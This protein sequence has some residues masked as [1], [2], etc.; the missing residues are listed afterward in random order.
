MIV[1]KDVFM[2]QRLFLSFCLLGMGLLLVGCGLLP[3]GEEEAAAT[4]VPAPVGISGDQTQLFGQATLACTETCSTR[5][6]CGTLASGER[7]VLL[8]VPEPAVEGH[9]RW[10]M[11]NT[12]VTINT[13]QERQ[14]QRIIAG[15]IYPLRFYQI[16]LPDT[17][18]PAWVA[19]WCIRQ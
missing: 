14:L 18:E 17:P 2:K 10:A 12:P 5:G 4:A 13:D 11:D 16:T 9:N 8:G 1:S 6:Q 3:G 19:G 15:D 7:V